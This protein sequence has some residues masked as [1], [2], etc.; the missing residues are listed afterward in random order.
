MNTTNPTATQR[1]LISVTCEISMSVE[2]LALLHQYDNDYAPTVRDLVVLMLKHAKYELQHHPMLH[3]Q[4]NYSGQQGRRIFSDSA[5][6]DS[7]S[8]FANNEFMRN[9]IQF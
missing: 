4:W 8:E 6:G 2:D 3:L 5:P 7:T 9:P 1:D